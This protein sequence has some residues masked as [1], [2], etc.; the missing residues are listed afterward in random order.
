MLGERLAT[1]GVFRFLCCLGIW[2]G[3]MLL[4]LWRWMMMQWSRWIC[5]N[6]SIGTV[7]IVVF[8][9]NG[10]NHGIRSR[11]IN[12]CHCN[13]NIKSANNVTTTTDDSDGSGSL[14]DNDNNA[15][16]SCVP[17]SF[18]WSSLLSSHFYSCVWEGATMLPLIITVGTKPPWTTRTMMMMMIPPLIIIAW[19]ILQHHPP[20]VW[21]P[22]I[23][24]PPPHTNY[25]HV[26]D[27]NSPAQQQQQ[28]FPRPDNNWIL[29][30]IAIAIMM[31]ITLPRLLLKQQC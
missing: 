20:S 6:G 4:L 28:H 22:S 19:W 11:C 29:L 25:C 9:G 31:I 10:W 16:I 23:N 5:S 24:D 8:V 27:G 26:H 15:I 18:L 7:G 2:W 13:N 12:N 30:L 21:H 1:L 17:P 14:C 3:W